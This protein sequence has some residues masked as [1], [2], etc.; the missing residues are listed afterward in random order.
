MAAVGAEAVVDLERELAGRRQ[1]QGAHGNAGAAQ[2][3]PAASRCRIG[4]AK[5]AVLPVPV[6]AQ[7]SRSR[8]VEE[9]RDGLSLDGGRLGIVLSGQGALQRLDEIEL[10]ESRH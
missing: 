3:L 5:A 2:R 1:H 8:P 7:P 6:W 10:G 9:L 4:S